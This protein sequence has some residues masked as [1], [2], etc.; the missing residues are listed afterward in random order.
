MRI[1]EISKRS[2]LPA[3]TIRH[4]EDVGLIRSPR[5]ENGYRFFTDNDLHKLTFI[6]QA[7][8]LGFT[9]GDC[10]ILLG[11]YE[12]RQRASGDVKRVALESLARLERKLDEL[13]SMR[14]ALGRLVERCHGDDRPECPIIDRLAGSSG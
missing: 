13:E 4:Y 7:R 8:S 2:G 12:D 14:A 11:L 1:G 10:R 3:K 5:S 6:A 9:L